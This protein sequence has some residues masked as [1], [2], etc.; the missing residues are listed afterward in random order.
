MA[1]PWLIWNG[2]GPNFLHPL[3]AHP[4]RGGSCAGFEVGLWST[5]WQDSQDYFGNQYRRDE[6]HH[7]WCWSGHW[8]R[9]G[10]SHVQREVNRHINIRYLFNIRYVFSFFEIGFVCLNQDLQGRWCKSICACLLI[11]PLPQSQHRNIWCFNTHRIHGT[12]LLSY[13]RMNITN[14]M[15]PMGYEPPYTYMNI[16]TKWIKASE[17]CFFSFK[18]LSSNAA[19]AS[20]IGSLGQ[21]PEWPTGY[22]LLAGA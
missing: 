22:K 10:S 11:W 12:G 20:G 17:V 16:W 3:G 6:R 7:W 13:I 9:Q 14:P 2:G 1:F 5:A 19:M 4:P 18:T 21:N 15:D 8:R